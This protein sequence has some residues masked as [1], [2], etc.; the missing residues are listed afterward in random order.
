MTTSLTDAELEALLAEPESD[1]AERKLAWAGDAP[2][3]AR[4][5]V[6]AFANDL[7]GHGKPGVLFVGARDDGQPAGIPV[8]DQL[9]L[10]LSDLRSDGKTVPPPSLLV[11][12]RVLRGAAMA[13][14][15]VLPS[16]TPPVRYEGRIWVRIGPRRGLATA[17]DE[18]ILNERRRFLDQAF[19]THPI[20]GCPLSELSR[21][22]FEHE[23]LPRAVAQDVLDANERSYEQRLASTGMVATVDDPTPTVVGLLTLGKTPRTWL[24]C[25]YI[26]YL[27]IRGTEW[28]DSVADAQE[29]A[30]NLDQVLRRLDDK[31]RATLAVAVDFTNGNTVEERHSAYPLVALQQLARNA[32]MHRT[33]EHTNAPVRFYWFDDRIEIIN[34]GG[35]FGAVTQANFGRPGVSDYR[36]PR[37][38]DAL[39]T[40]GFVQ[41][42][43]FGIADARKALAANGNPELE[44][45]V[46]P[47]TVLATVRRAP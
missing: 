47:T 7:P 17:Q 5:A 44:Y 1:R 18:R 39:K 10:T 46:E 16:D 40:L 34:P 15:T 37:I 31:L 38:A 20:T 26:Q 29:I 41:R 32:V 24:P 36:N 13:V 30:G 9:L 43:G 42:F 27:R 8:T 28:G 4:Q 35:P 11:E 6:C 2:E 3:K 25:A 45:Q 12:K 33:Y 19:D 21:S 22:I 23:Y 14:V